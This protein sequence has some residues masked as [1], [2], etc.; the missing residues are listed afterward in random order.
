LISLVHRGPFLRRAIESSFSPVAPSIAAVMMASAAVQSQ[1][2]VRLRYR[3]AHAEV[4][5]RFFDPYGVVEHE[6]FWYTIGYCDTP[7]GLKTNGF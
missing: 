3:S 1:H 6:G 4:T 7:P 5:E 2:R